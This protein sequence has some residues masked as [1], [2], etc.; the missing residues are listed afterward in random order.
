MGCKKQGTK[1]RVIV[2]QKEKKQGYVF[3]F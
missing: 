1:N 3:S 2:T